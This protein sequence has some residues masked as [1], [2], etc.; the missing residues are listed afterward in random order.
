MIAQEPSVEARVVVEAVAPHR[1]VFV[2]KVSLTPL[3]AL[4]M[5]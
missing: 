4:F 2:N 5:N 1:I 3:A